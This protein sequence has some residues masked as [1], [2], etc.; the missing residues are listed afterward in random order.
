M[1]H[2]ILSVIIPCYNN[3]ELLSEMIECCICQ[4]FSEWELIIVD[5]QSTDNRS[6]IIENYIKDDR[7]K[8]FIRDREPKGSVVCRN[9]GFEKSTGK[10]VMH[11]DADDLISSTCFE[12]RVK[13]M[14]DNPDA[15]YAS[16]P[17][18]AFYD[19]DHLPTFNSNA[20]T[21]GV[22]SDHDDLL[23][24]FLEVNYPFS[25]WNN[26]YKR[27]A[28]ESIMWDEKV[29][30]YTDFSFIVPCILHNLKHKFSHL[31][32]IDYFYRMSYTSNN[33]CVSFVTREKCESTIYLFDK[34]LKSLQLL[35]DYNIRKRQYQKFYLLQ[36]E[37]LI[38][39]KETDYLSDFLLFGKQYFSGS[40][41]QKIN[42]ANKIISKKFSYKVRFS[43]LYLT[44]ALLF[45]YPRYM[46]V[47]INKLR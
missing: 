46:N 3:V 16:F 6:A 20:K 15:D 14:E 17:A 9:I 7:I 26:I 19:P 22:G 25:V 45:R 8:F 23:K 42:I 31:Q 33:M 35:P 21:W 2:F 43:I 24:M 30:I 32:E 36:C 13:F 44:F 10:Y 5:D 41:M 11:L 29:K 18:K 47:F 38:L 12:N 27:S 34:T 28:I 39:N 40:F 4:S 37:R 1:S